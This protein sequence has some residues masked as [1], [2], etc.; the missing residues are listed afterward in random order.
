MTAVLVAL[1][2]AQSTDLFGGDGDAP[3]VVE[4]PPVVTPKPKDDAPLVRPPPDGE[5][6][7]GVPKGEDPSPLAPP[8]PRPMDFERREL[9][10][11]RQRLLDAMPSYVPPALL[12]TGG[13]LLLIAGV[14]F[15]ATGLDA[16][17]KGQPGPDFWFGAPSTLVGLAAFVFGFMW[18][19]ERSLDREPFEARIEEIEKE[20]GW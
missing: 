9:A 5:V 6:P 1:V 8:K 13:G 3:A 4:P 20:L 2:L 18:G 19:R 15:L 7:D 16:A 17:L 12:A 14:S 10:L 11:E